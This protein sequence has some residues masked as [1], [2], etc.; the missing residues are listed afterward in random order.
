M[1]EI[2]IRSDAKRHPNLYGSFRIPRRGIQSTSPPPPGDA[3]VLV[4]DWAMQFFS[5]DIQGIDR[6]PDALR[7]HFAMNQIDADVRSKCNVN[8]K[9]G[10]CV[11]LS[12]TL[13]GSQEDQ[14]RNRAM[15]ALDIHKT[16]AVFN[17]FI[18]SS[19]IRGEA[20]KSWS[21]WPKVLDEDGREDPNG[22]THLTGFS[23][24]FHSPDRITTRISGYDERPWP[25]VDFVF[26]ITDTFNASGGDIQLASSED[27]DVDTSILNLLTGLFILHFPPLGLVFLAQS[28]YITT[29]DFPSSGAR[30]A[31]S[32]VNGYLP[33]EI[34]IDNGQKV[35]V[36][37]LDKE[38]G[39]VE[40]SE[41]GVFFGGWM[42]KVPREPSLQ[43]LGPDRLA[44]NEGQQFV[45]ANYNLI[46]HDLRPN[47]QVE[48][49]VGDSVVK[50]YTTNANHHAT[51]I[52]FSCGAVTIDHPIHR[53]LSVKV[54]D[55]DGLQA[56]QPHSVNI[57]ARRRPTEPG[58]PPRPPICEIR[59]WL[60]QCN[61]DEPL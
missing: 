25:D 14:A 18:N 45:E 29:K 38:F 22:P 9:L 31:G 33:R 4:P 53:R 12:T 59:P 19:Y 57:H 35:L 51:T 58:Q 42:V 23:V 3:P 8:N 32:Y 36:S 61:P 21:N 44:V 11:W 48:W 27:L 26:T 41:A 49:S 43:I 5:C 56:V 16:G 2:K 50:T 39:G 52:R 13:P 54:T 37:Y 40:V 24:N 1:S 28:I 20:D 30:G 15:D 60:P 10:I 46:S 55:A 34:M 6:I 7:Q 17:L 47:L